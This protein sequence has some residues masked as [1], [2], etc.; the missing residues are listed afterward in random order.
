MQNIVLERS[1]A[2]SWASFQIMPEIIRTVADIRALTNTWRLQCLKVGLVATM[3]ALHKGHLSLIHHATTEC[4]KV[5]VSIFVNPKQFSAREDLE[6]YPRNEE[7]D[8]AALETFDVSIAY[9]PP[10]QEIYDEDFATRIEVGHLTECMCG[11]ARPGFFG[12]VATVVAKLLNQCVP[13]RA[14]FGEKDYQQLLV[15]RQ[16]VKDLNIPTEIVGCP[17]IRDKNGLALSSR[18]AYLNSQQRQVATALFGTL[19]E[20]ASN[21]IKGAHSREVEKWAVNTLKIA[22]FDTVEYVDVRDGL[23]LE[24]TD[25]IYESKRSARIFGAATLGCARLIDNVP[26]EVNT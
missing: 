11:T 21:L 1:H 18:N 8:L 2:K 22:G 19:Q 12:G 25:D 10:V 14:Y 6:T 26:V 3:G 9:A 24:K 7:R 16:L 17:I 23:T 5:I 15:I 4:D 13:H 20:A